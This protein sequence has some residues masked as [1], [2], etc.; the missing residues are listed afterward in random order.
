MRSTN[1][2]LGDEHPLHLTTASKKTYHDKASKHVRIKE[3]LGVTNIGFAHLFFTFVAQTKRILF[4]HRLYLAP[5]KEIKELAG[6]VDPRIP[7]N[8]KIRIEM[9]EYA[10]DVD[11]FFQKKAWA[12]D[13]T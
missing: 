11:V 13:V 4:A 2:F 6:A 9:K 8:N 1:L 10:K 12:D 7:M 3:P 5:K